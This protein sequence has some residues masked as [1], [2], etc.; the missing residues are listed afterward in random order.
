LVEFDWYAYGFVIGSEYRKK[1][2]N[3]LTSSPK[4]PKQISDSTGLHLNHV[5]ATLGDLEK[6]GIVN[7]LTPK[8]RKGKLFQLT[9]LGREIT[10]KL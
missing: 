5:S 6:L 7:C 3:S 2:V 10:G 1:V 4:T 8:L 9:E